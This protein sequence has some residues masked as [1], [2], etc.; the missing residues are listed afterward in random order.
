MYYSHFTYISIISCELYSYY[1]S[2]SAIQCY[3]S[4]ILDNGK[5][6]APSNVYQSLAHYECDD[7]YTLFGPS[8]RMCLI[9]GTWSGYTPV[10]VSDDL[11]EG[12]IQYPT[13]NTI[14]V[15]T[16]AAS[17]Y[18]CTHT[19]TQTQAYTHI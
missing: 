12:K 1:S 5:V 13:A 2:L 6:T 16:D 10:C 15:Y 3:I 8:T 11:D 4:R 9:T 19:H 18:A 17:T 7:G 14:S